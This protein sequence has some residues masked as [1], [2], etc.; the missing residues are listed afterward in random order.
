MM[1]GLTFLQAN[2]GSPTVAR[3]SL[4]IWV[5]EYFPPQVIL[6]GVFREAADC[7]GYRGL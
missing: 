6:R 4:P 2:V 3:L 7:M 5:G 1:L